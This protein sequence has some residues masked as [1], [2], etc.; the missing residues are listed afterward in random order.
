MIVIGYAYMSLHNNGEFEISTFSEKLRRFRPRKGANQLISILDQLNGLKLDGKSL[1]DESLEHYKD[2]I[3]SRSVIVVI[4]D[5]LF[6][7]DRIKETLFRFKKSEVVVIQVLDEEEKNLGI[8]GDL[9]LQ[10]A[11]QPQSWLRTFITNR[12]RVNYEDQLRQHSSKLKDI[13]ESLNIRFLSVSTEKPIFD[14][15]YELLRG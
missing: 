3:Q 5:F 6:P 15:F 13:C 4:S 1:F 8:E 14:T 2:A 7:L 9:I 10:D 11:E 12:L